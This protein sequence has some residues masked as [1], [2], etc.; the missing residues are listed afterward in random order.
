MNGELRVVDDVAG[1]F[2][3]EVV[4]AFNNRSNETF[5]FALCG[6]NTGRACYEALSGN[7]AQ[8]IDWWDVDFY[9]G[10]ERCVSAEDPDSNQRMARETL[11][12]RVGAAN[13][14][15]PMRCEEGPEAY[16]IRLAEVGQ[17][18]LVHLG[19][20]ADGH[21]ASLF[22]DS[23]A[24]DSGPGVLVSFNNDIHGRNPHRRMTLTL[25][26]LS[27]AHLV[28]ITVTGAAKAEAL[29][30]VRDGAALPASLVSAERVLWLVDHDAAPWAK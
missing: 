27:R 5:A 23:P 6:G 8:S 30:A 24:L 26:G 3:D 7:A 22:P 17:F 1:A 2:V 29:A 4:G 19:M 20:G 16:Q 14:V 15:Y 11:L 28:V 18:D 25:S 13:A 10:D 12:E 9:W 21:V